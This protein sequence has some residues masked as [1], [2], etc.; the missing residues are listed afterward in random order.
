MLAVS[1]GALFLWNRSLRKTQY[2][3]AATDRELIATPTFTPTLLT[4]TATVTPSLSPVT[5]EQDNRVTALI[6][7]QERLKSQIAAASES[8]V[9][10]QIKSTRLEIAA[11][12]NQLREYQTA[13]SA[14]HQNAQTRILLVESLARQTSAHNTARISAIERQERV[15][16]RELE[17]AYRSPDSYQA[18]R[19]TQIQ[20]SIQQM[21]SEVNSLAATQIEKGV[22]LV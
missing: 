12:Q 2:Q 15:A 9:D 1:V 4:P 5:F 7:D 21:Q 13:E 14:L 22:F 11:L 8:S 6:Q 17:L 3:M 19:I 20:G 10:Q 18:D 16:Q